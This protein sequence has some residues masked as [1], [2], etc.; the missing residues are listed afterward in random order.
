M[1]DRRILLRASRNPL[2]PVTAE[3]TLEHDLCWGNSGNLLFATAAWAYYAV[4]GAE[5]VASGL[6]GANPDDA[7][8][9]NAEFSAF[10]LPLANAFRPSFV[11]HLEQ[12]TA[13]VRRLR[14]PVVVLGVGAQSDLTHDL[15][16]L[17]RL[18]GPVRAF[19]GAVLDRA[20]AI[21]VRGEFTAD[22]L[23]SVGFRDVEVIG[24]PSL[25][26]RGPRLAIRKP[27]ERLRDDARLAVSI[28]PPL[29]GMGPLVARA[30]R[31]YRDLVYVA[32]GTRDLE[33]MLRGERD[34]RRR[35]AT[36]PPV[37]L[38]HP[39][40]R[41]RRARF[42]VDAWPWVR[43]LSTRDFV[44]GSRI[45][46]SIAALLGRT[47]ALVLA[48]D[49]RTLEL[50]RSLGVPHARLTDLPPGTDAADLY[51]DADYTAFNAGYEQRFS[52]FVAFLDRHDVAHVFEHGIGTRPFINAMR[53]TNYPPPVRPSP[54]APRH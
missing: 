14:I 17:H 5:V 10:V 42:F 47:P 46:G 8:R 20:P 15:S 54:R 34:A 48:H 45:H 49:S 40:L 7:E 29:R 25:Y 32:Q 53:A 41:R 52:R 51:A 43:F 16:A 23:R 3:E 37:S 12:L 22:Y 44:F 18:A 30:A 38:G 28:N 6:T 33:L 4:P 35:R 39:L 2:V 1:S 31:R 26:L 11:P 13:F 19:V 9:V 50:A 27:H 21:G 24:C 36:A